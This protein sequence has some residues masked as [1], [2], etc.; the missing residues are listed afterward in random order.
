MT[1]WGVGYPKPKGIQSLPYYHMTGFGSYAEEFFELCIS[2]VYAQDTNSFLFV[3]DMINPIGSDF[4]LFQ[5]TLKKN[6]LIRYLT[7][8]P[9]SGYNIKDR[10]DLTKSIALR[11]PIPDKDDIFRISMK[12]FELQDRIREKTSQFFA[13]HELHSTEYAAIVCVSP[14]ME[15]PH[16]Y[17][18]A[19]TFLPRQE[20][21]L[22][23]VCSSLDT[24][25]RFRTAFPSCWTLESIHITKEIHTQTQEQKIQRLMLEIEELQ[26]LRQAQHVVGSFI[27]FRCRVVGLVERRFREGNEFFHSIDGKNFSLFPDT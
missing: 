27:D 21:N 12:L 19:L 8:Y 25:E 15:D 2:T 5:N 7:Y 11:G 3:F 23:I 16:V 10:K 6:S 9:T 18:Q 24:F 20:L 14:S 13:K 4:F 26:M 1:S 22:Y 17:L